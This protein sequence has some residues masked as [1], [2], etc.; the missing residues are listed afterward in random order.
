MLASPIPAPT[1]SKS[2]L[3]W[4]WGELWSADIPRA[5]KQKDQ[6]V[7]HPEEPRSIIR[8]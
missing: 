5:I 1:Y 8:L 2:S 7:F 6:S 4:D 3:L